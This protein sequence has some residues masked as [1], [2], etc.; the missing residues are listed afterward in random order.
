[1]SCGVG[2]RRN[3]DPALLWL[4]CRQA[5]VAPIRPLDW[6]PPCASGAALKKKKKKT[7]KITKNILF[8]K[9]LKHPGEQLQ[10]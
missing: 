3:S 10:F 7:K 4:R 9:I 6:K 5:A 8:R 2:G 1:M